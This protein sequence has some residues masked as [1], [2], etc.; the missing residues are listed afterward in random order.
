M[1][2]YICA[3]D[4]GCVRRIGD[5]TWSVCKRCD[6]NTANRQLL[7]ADGPLRKLDAFGEFGALPDWMQHARLRV[8]TSLT[9]DSIIDPSSLITL[10]D[11]SEALIQ[12]QQSKDAHSKDSHRDTPITITMHALVAL[13]IDIIADQNCFLQLDR[14]GALPNIDSWKE[15]NAHIKN[16]VETTTI[17]SSFF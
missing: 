15:A 1:T 14:F 2:C 16:V 7:L 3:I 10:S 5:V 4:T 8:S 6:D 17:S 11:K 9:A 13:N 12:L